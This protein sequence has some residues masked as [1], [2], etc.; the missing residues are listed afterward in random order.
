[1]PAVGAAVVAGVLLAKNV[2]AALE[3]LRA[4]NIAESPATEAS[5]A[6][7]TGGGGGAGGGDFGFEPI[8]QTSHDL[9]G[10]A[11]SQAGNDA[12]AAARHDEMRSKA[13]DKARHRARQPQCQPKATRASSRH[14]QPLATDL[15][16]DQAAN[17]AAPADQAQ[18]E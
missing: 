6:V 13:T 9:A 5:A 3:R 11:I 10:P 1:M 17:H 7:A 12:R 15:A 16:S 4:A 2:F 8:R 18:T 14:P